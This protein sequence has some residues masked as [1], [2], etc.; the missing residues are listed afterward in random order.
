MKTRLER[1]GWTLRPVYANNNK[2]VLVGMYW[3]DG[4][5]PNAKQMFHQDS[6][7]IELMNRKPTHEPVSSRI[8]NLLAT[9][10]KEML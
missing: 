4:S 1:L 5:G 9:S 6:W 2:A 7:L 3:F 10:P 8:V